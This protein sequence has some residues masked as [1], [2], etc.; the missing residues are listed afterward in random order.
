LKSRRQSRK[1]FGV[2]EV[3][4]PRRIQY[5]LISMTANDYIDVRDGGFYIKGTRVP[6]DSVVY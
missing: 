5:N 3:G 4:P 6:L 2:A 1:G